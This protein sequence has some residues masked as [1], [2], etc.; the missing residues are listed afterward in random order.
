ML[1]SDAIFK[2]NMV[3]DNSIRYAVHKFLEIL[4]V[5]VKYRACV[6]KVTTAYC[7]DEA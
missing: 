7:S 2:P 6:Q 1:F 3:S 5:I 4:I